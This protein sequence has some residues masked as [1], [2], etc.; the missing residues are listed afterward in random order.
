M[1]RELLAVD[2]ESV[3]KVAVARNLD[4]QQAR[5]RVAA[6][7]AQLQSVTGWL[8]PTLSPAV[9]YEQVD[10]TVRATQGN[11]VDATFQTV[12]PFFLAQWF[13]NPGKVVYEIVA[14]RK[15]MVASQHLERS[16]LVATLHRASNQYY[17]LV[18][19]QTRVAAS[20]QTV[21]E[22][23]ELLR[24][25]LSR[26]QGGNALP[27]DELR[28][29]AELAARE[30]DLLMAMRSFHDASV[31][32]AQTL[33]L[34]PTVTLAPGAAQIEQKTLV[35]PDATVE[36]LLAIAVR[37]RD[38]LEA[39]RVLVAASSAD[40]AAAAWNALGP[41]VGGGYQVG[42][43]ASQAEGNA[44]VADDW[45]ALHGQ[46][47]IAAGLGFSLDFAAL[48]QAS[49]ASVAEQQAFL[50]VNEKLLSVRAQVVRADQ[51]R[52]TLT[53]LVV[54]A[55]EQLTAAEE[56]LRLANANLRA[57]TMTLL[58][59]L[60]D[61]SGLARARLRFAEAVV[62]YNQAQIDLLAA[63]GVLDERIIAGGDTGAGGPRSGQP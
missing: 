30:Q 42:G 5:Q 34:D 63:L 4:V 21:A 53:G 8:L 29:K 58:D 18:L 50:D 35:R 2:L 9:L 59:V 14:A 6:Q 41:R 43:I 28:A 57:G 26:L 46:R 61:E 3:V 33:D 12:Q 24:I 32:L 7:R 48:G 54:H 51:D 11:L 31:S 62:R 19:A 20:R 40:A 10:G 13:L 39:V 52:R 16:T 44:G 37:H 45:T 17:E 22:V 49:A 15:R 1:Y 27:G 60:H 47:R 36:D 56:A 55:R 38:D 23:R 25:T